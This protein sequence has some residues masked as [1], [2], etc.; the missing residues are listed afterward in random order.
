MSKKLIIGISLGL[1]L[2]G[3]VVLAVLLLRSRALTD[4]DP[5]ASGVNETVPEAGTGSLGE[6]GNPIRGT[7]DIGTGVA[8]TVPLG[9]PSSTPICG[10]GACSAGETQCTLDCGDKNQRF[11]GTVVMK[12]VTPTSFKI[13]WKTD[14]PSTGEVRWGLTPRHELGTAATKRSALE[15]DVQL[16][17]ISAGQ[18]YFVYLKV[19]EED[20]DTYEAGDLSFETPN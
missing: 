10:D 20:G 9:D 14:S 16:T 6:S 8:D 12:D 7:Q 18:S 5:S 11:F 4:E 17:G 19:V 3:A 2:V 1:V 15:N 13:A